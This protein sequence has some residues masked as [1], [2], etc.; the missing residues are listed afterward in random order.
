MLSILIVRIPPVLRPF[1]SIPPFILRSDGECSD[2][3]DGIENSGVETVGS[4]KWYYVEI[5]DV[6]IGM[7]SINAGCTGK[8]KIVGSMVQ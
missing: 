8:A 1:I 5:I 2:P 6:K 3:Y 4:S 7:R